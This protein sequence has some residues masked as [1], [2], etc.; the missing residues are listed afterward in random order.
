MDTDMSMSKNLLFSAEK[1]VAVYAG[2][3]KVINITST[4]KISVKKMF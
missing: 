4:F 3:L 2:P 1:V